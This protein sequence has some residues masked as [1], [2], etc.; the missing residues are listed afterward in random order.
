VP[1]GENRFLIGLERFLRK[2]S[3]AL[4]KRVEDAT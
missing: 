4:K 3:D 2:R 1:P